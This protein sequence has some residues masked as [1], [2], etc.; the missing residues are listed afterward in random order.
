M[1]IAHSADIFSGEPILSIVTITR[2]DLSGL[3]RTLESLSNIL[4]CGIEVIVV[5]GSDFPIQRDFLQFHLGDLQN[6]HLI[7]EPDEGIYEAM[8]KGLA[9]STGR[10]VWFLNGGDVSLMKTTEFLKPIR[11]TNPPVIIGDYRMK[12]GQHSIPRKAKPLRK[13]GHGLP[14]SHQAILYPRVSFQ[15]IG[16]DLSFEICADYASIAVLYSIGFEFT[17]INEEIAEFS[18]GGTSG[19]NMK[20]LAREAQLVQKQILKKRTLPMLSSSLKHCFSGTM[21]R[22]VEKVGEYRP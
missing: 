20:L 14:T 12:S 21:R 5:D 8:N 19:R 13:I 15:K 2:N 9:L 7:A 6:I 1:T 22:L 11:S 18:L 4:N 17:Y 10:Y 3:T 16:Y